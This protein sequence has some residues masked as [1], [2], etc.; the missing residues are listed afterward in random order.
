MSP[1]PRRPWGSQTARRAALQSIAALTFVL[2]IFCGTPARSA[3]A[4]V[5]PVYDIAVQGSARLTMCR[6]WLLYTSCKT[7]KVLLPER[8]VVGDFIELKYG[9]N[10]KTYRFRVVLIRREGDV[11][12]LLSGDSANQNGERIEVSGC[13]LDTAR[14]AEAR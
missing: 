1:I 4:A 5:E 6:N 3:T 8:I 11:C 14:S 13:R 9:S 2:P 7:H 12:V 10:P